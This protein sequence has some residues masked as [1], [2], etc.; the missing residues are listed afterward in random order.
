MA[1]NGKKS[2]ERPSSSL[3][4]TPMRAKTI[5][6][7]KD[8]R[9]S[10]RDHSNNRSFQDIPL[11]SKTELARNAGGQKLVEKFKRELD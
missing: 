4:E 9:L 3:Y 5:E 6:S 11:F 1:N 2:A 7:K 10:H 8:E